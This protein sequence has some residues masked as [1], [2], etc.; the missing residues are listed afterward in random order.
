MSNEVTSRYEA[1]GLPLPNPDTMCSG[2]CEGTGWVPIWF[3]LPLHGANGLAERVVTSA[4]VGVSLS[5]T[6]YEKYYALW[7]EAEQAAP[8]DDGWHFVVCP[9][10]QGTGQKG[11][12][13]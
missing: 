2:E 4:T 5:S 10:C 8:A 11:V 9:E 13:A 1:L 12:D 3:P 7:L 6:D